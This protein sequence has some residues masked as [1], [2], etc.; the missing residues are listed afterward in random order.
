MESL[1]KKNHNNMWRT[2]SRSERS[3][4]TDQ[5]SLKHLAKAHLIKVR[6]PN[7]LHKVNKAQK[8]NLGSISEE[9]RREGD[10]VKERRDKTPREI[11]KEDENLRKDE[12]EK[13]KQWMKLCKIVLM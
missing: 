3:T 9:K 2:K 11:K 7:C 5:A 10:G 13:R 4:N 1:S 8:I 12:K 6:S